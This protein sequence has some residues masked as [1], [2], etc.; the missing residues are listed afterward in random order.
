MKKWVRTGIAYVCGSALYA[1]SVSVF[2]TP[3][4][5]APGG[6]A[7]VGILLHELMGIPVGLTALAL[8]V[9]LL[10]AARILLGKGFYRRSG[11]VILLSSV[12]ID[13][14]EWLV[15]PYSDDRLLAALCGG[16]LSGIGVGIILRYFA[17]TGGTD[18]VAL[19][20]QRRRPHL[21]LGRLIL[22]VDAVVI[23]VSVAVFGELSAAL[24]ATVQVFVCALAVDKVV[25]G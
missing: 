7:G 25:A 20:L 21:S 8:N 14:T 10:F 22:L 6:T 15:P 9:P 18:I 12:M 3:N 23:A 1:L 5:I 11:A 17:S 19:L 13:L 16:V 4:D 24:Y 2:S